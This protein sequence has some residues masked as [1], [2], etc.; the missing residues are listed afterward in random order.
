MAFRATLP[1][2]KSGNASSKRWLERQYRDP[3]V[4]QRLANPALYRSRAA[5]KLLE[6]DDEY[7]FIVPEP[8]KYKDK[9]HMMGTLYMPY[10]TNRVIAKG[11]EHHP[12]CLILSSTESISRPSN[13]SADRLLSGDKRFDWNLAKAASQDEPVYYFGEMVRTH[14]WIINLRP[15]SFDFE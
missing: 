8:R 5:S 7:Q 12:T 14:F 10:Y 11:S 13:W 15:N 2:L 6:M 4:R 9:V 1:R 3:Y